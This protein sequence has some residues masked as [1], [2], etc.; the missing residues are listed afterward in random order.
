MK[1]NKIFSLILL[2][3]AG[4]L[5]VSCSPS[6]EDDI[7]EASAAERLNAA[8]SIYSARLTAQPNGWAM[9]LYPTLRDETPYGNGYLLLLRFRPNHTV[10]AAMQN[11]FTNN[12]YASDSS[13]WDVIT[14][15][16]PVLSFNTHNNVIHTFSDPE[17]ISSTGTD[18]VPNDETGTG[19]GGDYEFII[20]QAPEDASYMMLKGK[21]RSTYNLLTP[22]EQGVDYREY[23]SDVNNFTVNKFSPSYPNGGVMAVGD[24]VYHFDG[25][26]D[27]L[28]TIYALG[29]D[30]VTTGRFNPFL[31]T[32]LGNDYY[33]RFRDAF[34][35]NGVAEQQ[36]RY[37][38]I[39]DGFYGTTNAANYI[40]GYYKARFVQEAMHDGHKF[41]FT[42][43][44][45][46]SDAVREV[47]NTVI[48]DFTARNFGFTNVTMQ[49]RDSTLQFVI[50]WTQ[51]RGRPSRTYGATFELNGNEDLTVTY[52]GETN[53]AGQQLIGVVPSV[54]NLFRT[55]AGSFHLT[56]A[57]SNFNLS[58]IRFNSTTDENIWYEV[59]YS[60]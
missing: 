33:L 22:V 45:Q 26:A 15:D 37:D 54:E 59:S 5:M 18:D 27:G 53:D 29:Q 51:R 50:S 32:K 6:E 48:S 40:S 60:R 34:S 16:G 56:A 3:V 8:S 39:A 13:N 41:V 38:S 30:S 21:K 14:D 31:I 47:L 12:V 4:G 23:L 25:A 9:Q 1:R 2:A 19:V 46:M 7:F 58:R 55:L 52:T 20:V 28:P 35:V 44:S 10:D 11:S 49:E 42:A 57:I 24:S 17:D 36:F 43:N